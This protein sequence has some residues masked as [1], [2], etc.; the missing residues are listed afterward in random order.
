MKYFL[1]FILPSPIICLKRMF[2]PLFRPFQPSGATTEDIAL[3]FFVLFGLKCSNLLTDQK[4][5]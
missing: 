1:V 4:R 5:L 3:C 2:S